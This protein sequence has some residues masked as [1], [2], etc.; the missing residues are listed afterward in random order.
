MSATEPGIRVRR[1]VRVNI[2]VVYDDGTLAEHRLDA[3]PQMELALTYGGNG[4]TGAR[5][6]TAYQEEKEEP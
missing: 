6:F 2:E 4:H 5:Y 1:I 3:T